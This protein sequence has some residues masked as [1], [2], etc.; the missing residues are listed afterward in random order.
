M[1]LEGDLTRILTQETDYCD[2]R[3]ALKGWSSVHVSQTGQSQ[4]EME[5]LDRF[6]ETVLRKVTLHRGV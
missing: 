4:S 1:S 6:P 5:H 3:L 2:Y